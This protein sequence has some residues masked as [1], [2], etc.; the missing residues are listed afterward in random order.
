[1]YFIDVCMAYGNDYCI[2]IR[3]KTLRELPI[4]LSSHLAVVFV[5]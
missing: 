1:M 4:V 5:G 3:M 2:H